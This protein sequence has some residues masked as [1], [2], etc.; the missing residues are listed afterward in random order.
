M[1]QK[2]RDNIS[3]DEGPNVSRNF[4]NIEEVKKVS[5]GSMVGK[6]KLAEEKLKYLEGVAKQYQ[7]LSKN[8]RH[9][10]E[11]KDVE[12]NRLLQELKKTKIELALAHEKAAE[13]ELRSRREEKIPEI[14]VQVNSTNV[15]CFNIG[16]SKPTNTHEI[17]IDPSMFAD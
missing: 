13:D 6:S 2:T 7:N 9:E 3:P 4:P 12:I 16:S 8:L 17:R 10:T 14:T 11:A 1:E 5:E 15:T